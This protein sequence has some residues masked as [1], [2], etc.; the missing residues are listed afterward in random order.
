M[1]EC[2]LLAVLNTC[3]VLMPEGCLQEIEDI[4]DIVLNVVK[5]EM[6]AREYGKR[7]NPRQRYFKFRKVLTRARDWPRARAMSSR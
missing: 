4:L 2:L 7:S 3:G 5:D 1:R 6:G